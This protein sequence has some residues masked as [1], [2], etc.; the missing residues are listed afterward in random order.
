MGAGKKVYFIY[1]EWRRC[2][3]YYQND[4][5]VRKFMCIIWWSYCNSKTWNKI[6]RRSVLLSSVV[7]LADSSLQP[8]IYSVL[9]CISGKGVRK[10]ERGYID[11][12][13]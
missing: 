13:F 10:A 5:T 7:S 11:K 8:V 2:E 9:G 3:W 1:F 12:N 4:K 6:T